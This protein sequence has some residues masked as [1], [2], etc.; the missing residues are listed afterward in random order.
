MSRQ[1]RFLFDPYKFVNAVAYLAGRCTEATKMK[2]SKLLYYADKEHLLTY[3]RPIIGDRYIKMEYGPVP[4]MAY[5]LMKH[6]DRASADDQ[7]LFDE[8][9]AINGMKLSVTVAPDLRYLSETDLEVLD[10]VIARYGDMTP[11]TLSTLSHREPAWEHAQ[12]NREMDYRLMFA[13]SGA[14]E[15][16]E[17]VQA[18]QEIRDALTDIELEDFALPT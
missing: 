15:T 18:D 17:I 12:M 13:G 6:D 5:S 2:I 16:S 3:G 10:L 1:I 8:R 4:S 14:D 11:A 7:A 9:I